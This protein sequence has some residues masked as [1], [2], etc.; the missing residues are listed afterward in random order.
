MQYFLCVT[1]PLAVGPIL[2][3]CMSYKRK[4]SGPNKSAQELIPRDGKLSLALPC[5]RIEPRV[6]VFEDCAL[7]HWVTPPHPHPQHVQS[8]FHTNQLHAQ[9]HAINQYTQPHSCTPLLLRLTHPVTYIHILTT[10]L[11]PAK[12]KKNMCKTCTTPISY[13]TTQHRPT[14]T[15]T[16]T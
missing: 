5:Q 13:N 16:Q 10:N 1:I 6:F 11:T 8:H 4:G 14:I 12:D 2:L 9:K 7:Y 3:G 15:C